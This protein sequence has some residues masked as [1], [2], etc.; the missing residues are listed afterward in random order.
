MT[1]R[2]GPKISSWPIRSIGADAGEDR[3]LEEVAVGQ[4]VA[5]RPAAAEDELALA[6]PDVDVRRDL[7]E[8]RRR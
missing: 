3:R 7:V 1:D 2:T 6:A 4:A 5:G 8:R